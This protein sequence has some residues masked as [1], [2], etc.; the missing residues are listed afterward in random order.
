MG[1]S[2]RAAA[3]EAGLH[4]ETLRQNILSGVVRRPRPAPG[5][6]AAAASN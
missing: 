1:R 3:R 4:V 6:Q 2:L 5:A